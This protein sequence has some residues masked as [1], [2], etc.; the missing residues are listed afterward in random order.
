MVGLGIA[1]NIFF[2]PRQVSENGKCFLTDITVKR[3]RLVSAAEPLVSVQVTFVQIHIGTLVA[4]KCCRSRSGQRIL[5]SKSPHLVR[6]RNPHCNTR[7][8]WII[9]K[10]KNPHVLNLCFKL[11]IW[12]KTP[13]WKYVHAVY[14]FFF[15]IRVNTPLTNSI[16]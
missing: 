7:E 8:L 13:L 9:Y 11:W 2:V 15:L 16:C 10:K 1:V 12:M 6:F 14:D 4:G 3:G 5:C